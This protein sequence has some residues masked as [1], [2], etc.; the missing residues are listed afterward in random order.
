MVQDVD[1]PETSHGAASGSHGLRLVGH[2]QRQ[3]VQALVSAQCR[4]D[5]LGIACG[6]D[7]TVAEL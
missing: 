2:V 3:D 6:R 4:G 1:A 5:R 7:D